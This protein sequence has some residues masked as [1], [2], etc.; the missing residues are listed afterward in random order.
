MAQIRTIRIEI[1]PRGDSC[2]GCEHLTFSMPVVS[3]L[4]WRCRAFNEL[5]DHG[6]N[7]YGGLPIPIRCQPCLDAEV[8]D[9]SPGFPAPGEL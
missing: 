5:L 3:M 7:I 2:S 4:R 8:K 6:Q 1:A 9:E